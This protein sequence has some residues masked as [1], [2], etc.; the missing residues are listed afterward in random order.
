MVI[1]YFDCLFERNWNFLGGLI[2]C[3]LIWVLE[4][5]VLI[6]WLGLLLIIGLEFGFIIILLGIG[7][8]IE[9]I[10][11]LFLGFFLIIGVGGGVGLGSR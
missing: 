5:I 10:F 4:L 3:G 2:N 11:C 7:V 9:L 1:S 6:I 8:V